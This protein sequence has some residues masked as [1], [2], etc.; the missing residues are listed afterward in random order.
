MNRSP[1][2]EPAPVFVNRVG[3]EDGV[4]FW[5][6]SRIIAPGG[7]LVAAAPFFDECLVFGIVDRRD[8]LRERRLA[9]RVG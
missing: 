2:T 4:N 5:G 9:P 7:A 6:G 3:F 8:L 1:A